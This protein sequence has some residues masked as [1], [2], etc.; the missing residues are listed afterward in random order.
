MDKKLIETETKMKILKL[1]YHRLSP[2]EL[3]V[4]H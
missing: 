2:T 1:K 4:A 3:Y